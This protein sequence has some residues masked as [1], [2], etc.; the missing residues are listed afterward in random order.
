MESTTLGFASIWL[1]FMCFLQLLNIYVFSSQG[2]LGGE[3]NSLG[4]ERGIMQRALD[5]ESE[6]NLNFSCITCYLVAVRF[7]M[8]QPLLQ[9]LKWELCLRFMVAVRNIDNSCKS[10]VT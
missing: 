8:S 2:S 5:V 10:S 3:G 7:S 1:F 9:L 4:R 6:Q